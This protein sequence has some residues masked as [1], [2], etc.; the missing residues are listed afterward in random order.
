MHL[1]WVT[2]RLWRAAK[3]CW[4]M[5]FIR[6]GLRRGLVRRCCGG[7]GRAKVWVA[8]ASRAQPEM[9]AAW[10]DSASR[11]LRLRMLV[12]MLVRRTWECAEKLGAEC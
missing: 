1:L 8:T 10:D 6:R 9:I 7:R 2:A 5:T 4:W 12:G 3:F 11:E